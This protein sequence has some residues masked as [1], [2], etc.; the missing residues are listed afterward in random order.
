MKAEEGIAMAGEIARGFT[1][2][3]E[4]Y[5]YRISKEKYLLDMRAHA[6]EAVEEARIEARAEARRQDLEAARKMKDRG[7]SPEEIGELLPRLTPED[8]R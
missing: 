7:F 8:I 6:E 4:E 5:F 3:E 2:E 1:K